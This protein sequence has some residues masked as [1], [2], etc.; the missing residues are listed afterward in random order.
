MVRLALWNLSL[1]S[2]ISSFWT[3][4]LKH[5]AEPDV[6]SSLLD[7]G[8]S[9]PVTSCRVSQ[10]EPE[11]QAAKAQMGSGTREARS[12]L[13][14]AE[15]ELDA[16][17]IKA[18]ETQELLQTSIAKLQ[19]KVADRDAKIEDWAEQLVWACCLSC[20][21]NR[22]SS[23]FFT[24]VALQDQ[25]ALILFTLRVSAL[26]Y[27]QVLFAALH[28]D[29]SED[30][31]L[32]AVAGAGKTIWRATAHC[33]QSNMQTGSDKSFCTE[34]KLVHAGVQD[35]GRR[36]RQQLDKDLVKTQLRIN[37]L[38]TSMQVVQRPFC[39][40]SKVANSSCIC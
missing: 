13:E 6:F 36:E 37:G 9:E 4:S 3:L 39:D 33:L 32:I 8:T 11:L 16:T 27:P 40:I 26:S 35:T 21:R 15:R 24:T 20:S 2:L 25:A 14:Q 7:D 38:Q 1:K 23:I 28:L 18:E 31:H 10:L 19:K 12:K 17:A 22:T 30:A 34:A 29:S 5:S